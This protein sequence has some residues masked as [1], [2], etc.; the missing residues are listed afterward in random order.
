M[1]VVFELPELAIILV[2]VGALIFLYLAKAIVKALFSSAS[3]AVSWIPGVGGWLSGKAHDLEQKIVSVFASAVGGVDDAI[4]YML[5]VLAREA[6]WIGRE[7]ERH[8]QLLLSLAQLLPG[9]GA[10]VS[11]RDEIGTL[12]RLL[13]GGISG[14][15][16]LVK[17]LFQLE[18]RLRHGI[19][20][21]VFPRIRGVERDV[22]HV[23][24]HDIA[25]L[26]ARDKALERE[27]HNL[28][29]WIRAHPLSLATG[30]FAG[31][32]AVAL[33]RLGGSWIRCG[34]WNRIGR[35][36]CGL[37]L[38]L[39][40]DLLAVSIVSFAVVDMCEFASVAQDVAHAFVPEL[41]ALVDIEDA[42]IGCHGATGVPVLTLPPTQLPPNSIDLPLAA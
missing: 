1:P 15:L 33:Q 13:H 32:V 11:L 3:G 10:L 41:L 18:E 17:R 40:E 42:L 28:F 19:G 23:V 39:I 35:S 29:K 4:G 7:L 36:V 30:A 34:N 20:A 2:L 26:R 14:Q 5:H 9:A 8:A 12:R 16:S 21:D 31:A 27:Y 22:T 24:E 37:P 38:S 6:D 25:S